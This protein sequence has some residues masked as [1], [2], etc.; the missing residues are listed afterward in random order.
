M[1]LANLCLLVLQFWKLISSSCSSRIIHFTALLCYPSV[2]VTLILFWNLFSF[3]VII[4]TLRNVNAVSCAWESYLWLVSFRFRVAVSRLGLPLSLCCCAFCSRT[5]KLRHQD[6]TS[7]PLLR[8]CEH[9]LYVFTPG[10][11]ELKVREQSVISRLPLTATRACYTD[12]CRL[13]ISK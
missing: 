3:D 11:I 4:S 2:C 10:S 6:A 1:L 5:H 7:T 8:L 9:F 13:A 12:P